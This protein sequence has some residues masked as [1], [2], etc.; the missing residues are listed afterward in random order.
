MKD[1]NSSSP[2]VQ[3][4]W[5]CI[6]LFMIAM[7]TTHYF[8][9]E[10]GWLPVLKYN[11]FWE[12]WR[13]TPRPNDL[14]IWKPITVVSLY[15]SIWPQLVCS[16]VHNSVSLCTSSHGKVSTIFHCKEIK[17]ETAVK[18]FE[19]CKSSHTFRHTHTH[20]LAYLKPHKCIF[21]N[22]DCLLISSLAA[23]AKLLRV[24][25]VT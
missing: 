19:E 14:F 16:Q 9:R 23:R 2:V 25:G 8:L 1:S 24:G 22:R 7:D 11:T 10:Y 13:I 21:P 4:C 5:L 18:G 12:F 17:Y 3:H 6:F 15:I 20:T